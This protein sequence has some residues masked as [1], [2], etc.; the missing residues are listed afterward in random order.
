MDY[1]VGN[2]ILDVILILASVWMLI[3]VRGIGGI[4]GKTLSLVIAGAIILG[5]AHLIADAGTGL[6]HLA[7]P[8]NNF[9]HRLIV[10]V[11][12]ILLAL[13]FRQA[14]QLTR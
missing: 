4:M 8:L 9:I 11:G 10:L 2:Y 3:S 14:Q 6:F 5:M 7:G 12:F 13:G 1:T